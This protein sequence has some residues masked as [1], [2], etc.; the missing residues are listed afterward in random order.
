MTDL[1]DIENDPDLPKALEPLVQVVSQIDDRLSRLEHGLLILD[2]LP[3]H[4]PFGALMRV[5][6]DASGAL[7][8]GNGQ[9]QPITKLVPV[10]A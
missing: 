5:R 8:M 7:Y 2:V 6:G 3:A 4:A 9:N 1:D 10:L